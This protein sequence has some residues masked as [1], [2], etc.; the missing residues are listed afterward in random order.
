L[1]TIAVNILE[2]TAADD[3]GLVEQLTGLVN[4]VYAAAE[5]GLWREGVARTSPSELVTFIRAG[6]I[7]VATRHA[8]L[9][10]AVRIHDVAEDTGEFG[11]LVATP[12]QRGTG[13]GGELVAFAEQRSR[14]RGLRAMQLELLVP[15]GWRHPDKEFLKAWYTRL[16]YRQVG[17][18]SIDET[19]PHLAPLLAIPCDVDVYEKH[20]E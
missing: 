17:T 1:S 4:D 2:P 9:A 8:E 3:A 5:T 20:L 13:V 7:A 19:H 14:E 11:M 12:E 16:G 18:R 15:R 10:G 6:Q